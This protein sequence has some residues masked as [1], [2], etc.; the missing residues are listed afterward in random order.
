MTIPANANEH[1]DKMEPTFA[2][3]RLMAVDWANGT[4]RLDTPTGS[5]VSLR[6]D[7]SDI[8]MENRMR[9]L[10]TCH[11]DV[12]GRFG[13][14]EDCDDRECI[15]VEEIEHALLEPLPPTEPKEG[16]FTPEETDEFIRIIREGRDALCGECRRREAAV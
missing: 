1:P 10:A 13:T 5:S 15:N 11:I 4:A 7:T 14:V 2:K 3:G 16:P 8:D 12:W 6:F 9:K